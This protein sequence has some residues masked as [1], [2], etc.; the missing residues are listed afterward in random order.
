VFQDE[1]LD[2]IDLQKKLDKMG[3]IPKKDKDIQCNLTALYLPLHGTL[4]GSHD[5][6]GG[7]N[8]GNSAGSAI[9]SPHSNRKNSLSKILNIDELM[10]KIAQV[11]EKQQDKVSLRN[12]RGGQLSLSLSP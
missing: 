4:K 3:S 1:H 8:S 11:S 7:V 5:Y 12:L 2:Y 6:G 9:M 10:H